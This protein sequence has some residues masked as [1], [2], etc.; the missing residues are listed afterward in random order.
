MPSTGFEARHRPKTE[1]IQF[2]S[3]QLSGKTGTEQVRDQ[4][5]YCLELYTC[6]PNYKEKQGND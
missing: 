6:V 5:H 2:L 3:S 1:S 4:M